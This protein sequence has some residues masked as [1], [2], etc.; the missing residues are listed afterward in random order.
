MS[1]TWFSE[2]LIK[3][4]RNEV[5]ESLTTKNT[6]DRLLSTCLLMQKENPGQKNGLFLLFYPNNEF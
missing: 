4:L 2:T 1:V 3:Q 5:V 6:G